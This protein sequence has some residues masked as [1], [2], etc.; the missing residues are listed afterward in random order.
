MLKGWDEIHITSAFIPFWNVLLNINAFNAQLVVHENKQASTANIWTLHL[1]WGG[2]KFPVIVL[3]WSGWQGFLYILDLYLQQ[4]TLCWRQKK[5]LKTLL[6]VCLK[7]VVPLIFPSQRHWWT[8]LCLL[9]QTS[10]VEET[11]GSFLCPL[12]FDRGISDNPCR[13][14]SQQTLQRRKHK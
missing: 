5:K 13:Q 14:I 6:S 11:D 4:F 1:S 9:R 8:S 3:L 10:W 2:G 12:P 7:N